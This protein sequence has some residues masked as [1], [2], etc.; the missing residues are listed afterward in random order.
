MLFGY[1]LHSQYA[2]LQSDILLDHLGSYRWLTYHE[3]VCQQ[4]GKG[5]LPHKLFGTQHC[6]AQAQGAGLADVAA[7]HVVGG[8]AARQTQ[9]G[10]FACQLKLVLE[11]V[12]SI[13]MVFDTALC[14]AR[15][16]DHVPNARSIG[17]FICILNKRFIDHWQHF[18]G[19]GFGG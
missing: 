4:H 17:F 7:D 18:F 19:R 10:C 5:F 2:G 11:L 6:M 13:K 3:V 15:D 14:A 1:V 12:G 9:K 8:N 16:K